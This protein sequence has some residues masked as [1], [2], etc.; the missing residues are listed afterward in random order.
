MGFPDTTPAG[1]SLAR[2]NQPPRASTTRMAISRLAVAV[3]G[4]VCLA[5][6]ARDVARILDLPVSIAQTLREL[7]AELGASGLALALTAPIVIAVISAVGTVAGAVAL[8]RAV[9]ARR[10]ARVGSTPAQRPDPVIAAP[11]RP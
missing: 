4:L 10:P 9:T 8:G 3:L 7:G 5:W 6:G 1:R 2:T 11:G